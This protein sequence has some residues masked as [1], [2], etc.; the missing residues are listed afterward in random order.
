[1][2]TPPDPVFVDHGGYVGEE[3]L[4]LLE[5]PGE[6]QPPQ[7]AVHHGGADALPRGAHHPHEVLVTPLRLH[8]P[9]LYDA[10]L[11]VQI[12]P[13][14][15]VAL[16][17]GEKHVDFYQGP[18]GHGESGLGVDKARGERPEHVLLPV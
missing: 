13:S 2:T 11:E 15:P 6:P 16:H 1:M 7:D 3:G 9:L 14:P 17:L 5:V 8:V 12:G 4:K 10:G 18:G